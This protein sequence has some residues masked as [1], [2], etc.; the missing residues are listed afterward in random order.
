MKPAPSC[1]VVIPTHTTKLNPFERVGM[2]QGFR[3]LADY[4]IM[5]VIPEGTPIGDFAPWQQQLQVIY[6]DPENFTSN[7]AYNLMLLKPEFYRLFAAYDYM[8][9]YQTDVFIFR[10]ELDYWLRRGFDY[11]GAPW[12]PERNY[13]FF[14]PR[15]M[16]RRSCGGNGGF[17]LRR[18]Q[19]MV[20]LL[21]RHPRALQDLLNKCGPLVHEDIWWSLYAPNL[22]WRY[23][24][25]DKK[26]SERFSV[27][28]D[29]Q[30]AYKRNG[31]RLPF[32]CHAWQKFQPEF[33]LPHVAAQGYDTAPLY[34]FLGLQP[35]TRSQS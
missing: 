1:T 34:A 10:N 25:A 4:S 13:S 15:L 35:P 17:S 23:K 29:P 22:S 12:S 11:I 7:H 16:W 9:I 31:N 24:I 27:E 3:L 8:L 21:E 18:V 30:E 26:T 6:Q 2:A 28:V 20:R 14:Y 33:W 32:G 5:L 19:P